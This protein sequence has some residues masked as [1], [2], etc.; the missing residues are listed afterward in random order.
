MDKDLDFLDSRYVKKE[1]YLREWA[2]LKETIA[3]I[4]KD[5]SFIKWGIGILCTTTIGTLVSTILERVI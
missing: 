5:V 2:L 4:T 1:D 3:K